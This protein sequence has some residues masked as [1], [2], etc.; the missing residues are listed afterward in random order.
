MG[1]LALQ[2]AT[3]PVG[4]DV[5]FI[6]D[7]VVI[8]GRVAEES[9]EGDGGAIVL[10]DATVAGESYDWFRVHREAVQAFGGREPRAPSRPAGGGQS[11]AAKGIQ[12]LKI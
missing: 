8:T 6:V 1:S 11:P 5:V 3:L 2:V 7:G 9:T 10:K 4:Q 12:G